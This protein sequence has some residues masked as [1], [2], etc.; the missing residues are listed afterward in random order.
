MIF[1][2]A[3]KSVNMIASAL[4]GISIAGDQAT[5]ES[6]LRRSLEGNIVHFAGHSIVEKNLN[7]PI[8]YFRT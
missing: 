5:R 7:F 6:F 1:L 3:R 4:G 8:C 2:F